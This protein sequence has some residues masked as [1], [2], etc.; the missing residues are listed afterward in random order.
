RPGNQRAVV[1]H[2]DRRRQGC[3]VAWPEFAVL[4]GGI[5]E[6]ADLFP[7]DLG[8][9]ENVVVTLRIGE[10]ELEE[11][12]VAGARVACALGPGGGERL[13]Q[14]WSQ[15]GGV[16]RSGASER[17]WQS[18]L[19]L[20]GEGEQQ[21]ALGAEPLPDG[22]GGDAGFRGDGAEGQPRRAYS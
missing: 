4:D 17:I 15:G 19:G 22:W 6:Q 8:M 20:R 13:G 12:Q 18:W 16:R 21:V 11:R 14:Q 3:C 7:G 5:Q 9:L 2:M 1:G 10:F